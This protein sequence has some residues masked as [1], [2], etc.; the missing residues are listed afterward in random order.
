MAI[1]AVARVAS[2][3]LARHTDAG[4]A[5]SVDRVPVHR[6]SFAGSL[7]GGTLDGDVF[8]TNRVPQRA[9]QAALLLFSGDL[10]FTASR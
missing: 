3:A 6:S 5:G 4:T 2:P 10:S 9:E 8:I 1:L 7:E